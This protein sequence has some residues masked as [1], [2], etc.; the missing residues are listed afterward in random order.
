LE[1]QRIERMVPGKK[2]WWRNYYNGGKDIKQ[3]KEKICS[4]S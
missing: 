4:Q 3:T 1:P 2:H